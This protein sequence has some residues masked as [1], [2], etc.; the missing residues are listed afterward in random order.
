MAASQEDNSSNPSIKNQDNFLHKDT[1]NLPGN[2][3]MAQSPHMSTTYLVTA[4]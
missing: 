1:N 3:V 2:L 4:S